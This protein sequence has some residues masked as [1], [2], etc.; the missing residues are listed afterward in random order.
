MP[1]WWTA[2][3]GW[4]GWV[5]GWVGVEGVASDAKDIYFKENEKIKFTRIEFAYFL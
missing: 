2:V 1:Q 5:G 3:V 4:V